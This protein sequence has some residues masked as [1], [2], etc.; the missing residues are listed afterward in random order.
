MSAFDPTRPVVTR[1]GRKARI[2]ATHLK[3]VTHPIVA[4]IESAAGQEVIYTF[5]LDGAMYADSESGSDLIGAPTKHK[6]WVNLYRRSEP[7]SGASTLAGMVY[8][9]IHEA[10]EGRVAAPSF[11]ACVF[12]EWE[13]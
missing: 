12:I 13:E 3:D 1:D 4:A 7:P 6:G 11:V 9:T 8:E 10:A 2:L 5:T